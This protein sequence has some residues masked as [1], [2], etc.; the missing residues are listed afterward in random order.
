MPDVHHILA[1]G[2]GVFCNP[3][4]ESA[5]AKLRLLYECAPLAFIAEVSG[6]FS[7]LQRRKA[8]RYTLG[9]RKRL[10]S[11]QTHAEYSGEIFGEDK[12]VFRVRHDMQMYIVARKKVLDSHGRYHTIFTRISC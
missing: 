4:S 8:L 10:S 1:K 12:G 5:P 3:C 6:S 11:A 9:T 2:S 7:H